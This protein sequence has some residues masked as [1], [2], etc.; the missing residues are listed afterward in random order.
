MNF[1]LVYGL[2]MLV[3]ALCF[4][5][6]KRKNNCY[7]LFCYSLKMSSLAE[8]VGKIISTHPR[9]SAHPQGPKIK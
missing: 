6:L 5:L 4:V 7:P 3:F 2:F 1:Y 9:I 8:N